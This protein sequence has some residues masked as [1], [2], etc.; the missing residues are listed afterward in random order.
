MSDQ[1]NQNMEWENVGVA[2]LSNSKK[3]LNLS[4]VGKV[5]VIP[6]SN[7]EKVIRGENSTVSISASK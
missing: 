2:Y 6:L 1:T 4:L 7:L 3:A 5:F